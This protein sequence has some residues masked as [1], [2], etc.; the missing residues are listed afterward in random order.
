MK[1]EKTSPASVTLD[2]IAEKLGMS[3]TTVSRVLNDKS[4]QYRI[5]EKTEKLVRQAAQELNY[6]PNQ[7]AR[8]L[9]L[10]RTNI[11]GYIIPDLSNFF[12]ANV[13]SGA[14]KYLRK[15]GISM[16]FSNSEENILLEKGALKT[17]LGRK[18]DG[19]L[20]SPLGDDRT[21]LQD[22]VSRRFPSVLVDRYLP[23]IDLPFVASDNFRGSYDAV[24][25]LFDKGHTVIG[26]IRG[27]TRSTSTTD[28]VRGF[29][30]AHKDAG[31]SLEKDQISGDTYSIENGY[32][33]AKLMINRTPRPTAVFAL[34]NQIALGA[35]R[36][37]Q[38]EGI[39]IPDDIS[40]ITFDDHVMMDFLATPLTCVTQRASEM[41]AI[42]G[43]MLLEQLESTEDSKPRGL[44]LPTTLVERKSVKS[45]R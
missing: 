9:R 6:S 14:E 33:E 25:Y 19:V 10:R 3:A 11:T 22:L 4:K 12:F 40:V 26:C 31:I 30:E 17:L 21:H 2:T 5:S 43:K 37:L 27:Q 13:S 28:R 1:K 18:I 42:A 32:I 16:I 15:N 36:A 45:I 7:L 23:D 34:N 20:I 8:G 41:G 29:I 38:E 24:K 44:F 35:M 39:R